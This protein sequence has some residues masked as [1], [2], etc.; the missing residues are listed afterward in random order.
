MAKMKKKQ[1]KP[2]ASAVSLNRS[3]YMAPTPWL[4]DV[5]F[6]HRLNI[7]AAEFGVTQSRLAR[8]IGSKDKGSFGSKAME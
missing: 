5:Y 7:E 3:K 2:D 8:Y 6:T 4:E 1:V